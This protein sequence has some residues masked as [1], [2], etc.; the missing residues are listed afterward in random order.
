M[1]SL[2]NRGQFEIVSTENLVPANH[3]VR[4]LE[5]YIDLSFVYDLVDPLYSLDNNGRPGEDPMI[6]VK[7]ALIMKMFGID[8]LRKTYREL[9]VNIA[10]KWYLGFTMNEKIPHFT[11]FI[12]FYNDRFGG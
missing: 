5:K 8:S 11:S 6:Y 2:D 4:K 10:Y 9:E 7:I 1:R 3:F 12:H